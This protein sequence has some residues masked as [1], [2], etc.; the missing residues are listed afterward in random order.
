MSD[1]QRTRAL[2]WLCLNAEPGKILKGQDRKKW[3]DRCD[4]YIK[5]WQKEG[6]IRMGPLDQTGRAAIH[7]HIGSQYEQAKVRRDNAGTKAGRADA[8]EAQDRIKQKRILVLNA[9]ASCLPPH[10]LK[11][12]PSSRN[13]FLADQ[14]TPARPNLIAPVYPTPTQPS[15]TAPPYPSLPKA[16]VQARPPPYNHS[17]PYAPT[18]FQVPGFPHLMCPVIEITHATSQSPVTVTWQNPAPLEPEQATEGVH[19]TKRNHPQSEESLKLTAPSPCPM[20]PGRAGPLGQEPPS[21]EN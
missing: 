10:T 18:D 3:E 9:L 20:I 2:G 6:V 4:V 13:P 17:L 8:L 15:L 12:A 11:P 1:E 5:T 14:V 16:D 7:A 19:F 21:T